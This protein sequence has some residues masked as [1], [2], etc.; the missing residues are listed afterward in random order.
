[1]NFINVMVL[2]INDTC[3]VNAHYG[4]SPHVYTAAARSWSLDMS[5]IY[6]PWLRRVA[7]EL[8]ALLLSPSISHVYNNIDARGAYAFICRGGPAC[9]ERVIYGF[10]REGVRWGLQSR[11]MHKTKSCEYR[12]RGVHHRG[13]AKLANQTGIT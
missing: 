10:G 11:A 5:D 8:F 1:M 6:A 2:C 13:L 7:R 4:T 12:E 9:T 3:P